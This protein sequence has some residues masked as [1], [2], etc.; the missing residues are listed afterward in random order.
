MITAEQARVLSN[1]ITTDLAKEQ[2]SIIE[3][4]ILKS[5]S[6]GE[7]SV[8]LTEIY[9]YEG[10][11]VFLESLGYTCKCIKSSYNTPILLIIEW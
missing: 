3:K 5:A 2:L 8:K 4:A 7:N 11:V 1:E 9:P 6:K 10:I